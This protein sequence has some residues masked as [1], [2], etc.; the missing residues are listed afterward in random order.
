MRDRARC[1]Y[2]ALLNQTFAAVRLHSY[3]DM[4]IVPTNQA[5]TLIYVVAP[6]EMSISLAFSLLPSTTGFLER[7][8]LAAWRNGN[9]T[10]VMSYANKIS[11][12]V[13]RVSDACLL[14]IDGDIGVS[15]ALIDTFREAQ[16][17]SIPLHIGVNGSISGRADFD[18]VLAI[19]QRVLDPDAIARYLPIESDEGEGIAGLFD[20]LT[21]D[22]H[23]LTEFG[24]DAR[25]SDPEHV[26]LTIDKRAD[27]IEVLSHLGFSDEQLAS[28][29]NGNPV[30]IPALEA[31]YH[32]AQLVEVT[33]LD[34]AVGKHIVNA[35]QSTLPARWIPTV[36]QAEEVR[37]VT[38]FDAPIGIGIAKGLAR[39]WNSDRSVW[40][41]RMNS[42]G[43][44]SD[45]VDCHAIGGFMWVTDTNVG[46]TIRRGESTIVIRAPE[47]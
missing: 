43:A 19:C 37:D 40:L 47:F 28:L 42:R 35:W 12:E 1:R 34:D 13:L 14:I 5:Q 17:L 25:P 30:S 45:A 33:P 11:H 41:E 21:T 3:L 8:G 22:L 29:E 24:I 44:I 4:K 39:Y 31:A 15:P 6:A 38:T 26:S 32:D 10:F 36:E 18:E 2:Q 46:D 20:L 9:S 27:I 7:D 16:D 23:V